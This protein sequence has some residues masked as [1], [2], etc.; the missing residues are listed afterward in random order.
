MTES[1][2]A[3]REAAIR[4]NDACRPLAVAYVEAAQQFAAFTRSPEWR[5]AVEN[6][7]Q[8]AER[9]RGGGQ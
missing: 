6:L 1:E 8:G 9:L 4:L 7:R 2:R 5:V 3:I